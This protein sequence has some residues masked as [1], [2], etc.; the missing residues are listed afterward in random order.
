MMTFLRFLI[1]LVIKLTVHLFY[2]TDLTKIGS[3]NRADFGSV[4]LVLVLNHT[5]LFEPMY[6]SAC[7]VEFLWR[8]AKNGLFPGADITM[9]RP[10]A[11]KIIGALAKDV[12]SITRQRDD[13]WQQFL[14]LIRKES[15]VLMAPEGRMKRPNGLDK[16]GKQ[17][18]VRGGVADVMQQLDSG[19][20][21]LVY[22][23]GLHHVQAPGQKFPKLFQRIAVSLEVLE[24]S[25][26]EK[27]FSES[28]PRALRLAV[29]K[30]LEVRRDLHCRPLEKKFKLHS[31]L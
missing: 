1:L 6:V 10:L 30:H 8:I 31:A 18:T 23:G 3:V 14:K 12:V 20:I 2:K 16:Y 13:S 24:L 21:L 17:M 27:Q 5:S 25:A 22:S 29:A 19:K 15:V 7:P 9:G 11:G 26:F 4:S 28:D